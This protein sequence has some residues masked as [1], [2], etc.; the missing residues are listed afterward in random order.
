MNSNDTLV[1][2]L[3]CKRCQEQVPIEGLGYHFNYCE[4]LL[5]A[6]SKS[7]YVF[8]P[9]PFEVKGKTWRWHSSDNRTRF[10]R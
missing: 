6:Y 10:G 2:T 3:R 1:T 5:V 4:A 7:D 8:D 9:K